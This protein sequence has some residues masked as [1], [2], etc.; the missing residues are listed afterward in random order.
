MEVDQRLGRQHGRGRCSRP[1]PLAE[2]T[3]L[4]APACSR[5]YCLAQARRQLSTDAGDDVGAARGVRHVIL[6]GLVGQSSRLYWDRPENRR[7]LEQSG[8]GSDFANCSHGCL[9]R[10]STEYRVFLVA[11]G[12]FRGFAMPRIGHRRKKKTYMQGAIAQGVRA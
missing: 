5:Q 8:G 10:K 6:M 4:L 9:L 11:L 1:G 12:V 7:V 3:L 2:P